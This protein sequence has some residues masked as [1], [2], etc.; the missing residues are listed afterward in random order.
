MASKRIT[1]RA[2]D[3]LRCPPNRDRLFL[4]DDD[5]AG[6]GVAAM[7]SGKK[8]Y[9]AQYRQHGRSRRV[10]I[11]DHGRLTPDEARSAAKKVLGAVEGG[12][13]PIGQ[14]REGREARTLTQVA[15]DFLS[16]HA[17]AKRKARTADEYG[18][19]LELHIL[20]ALGS[21]IMA[22]IAK[23][24]LSRLHASLSGSPGA[25]NRVVA[26]FSAIWNWAAKR[27]EVAA[28][29]NPARQIERY[30]EQGRERYLTVEELRRLGKALRDAET[31]GLPWLIDESLPKAKHIPKEKRSRVIDPYAVAAIRLLMLTGARLREILEARWDYIDW[32]RGLMFLPDS[33]TGRKTLYL[34]K[35]ALGFLGS[36]PHID[37]NPYIIPGEKKNAPRADLKRPWAAIANAAGLVESSA[38]PSA[39]DKATKPKGAKPV[40]KLRL[41][42]RLHDLRHTFAA[43]GAGSSLGLPV[44]GKLLGH[45]QPA[46]TQ[47]YAHLDAD[48][49]HRAANIIGDQIMAAM[50]PVTVNSLPAPKVSKRKK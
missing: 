33:K 28:G 49:I 50:S 30:P 48:P 23:V 24:D 43:M 41:S 45:S 4:W 2:V 40:S 34:N 37:G 32:N 1:K 14:R 26:L 11:G 29:D 21:R 8:V 47:R 15:T 9:V 7:P 5:L 18:R 35:A 27:D 13:D 36:I 39:K 22:D 25:A 6:F 3:A 10:K 38:K 44:I 17:K 20:P 19:I 12:H 46:T 16:L 42:V 31:V